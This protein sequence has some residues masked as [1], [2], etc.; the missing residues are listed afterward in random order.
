METKQKGFSLI[1]LVISLSIL[2]V[3]GSS[4]AYGLVGGVRAYIS[5]AEVV[6]TLD[7]LRYASERINRELREIRRSQAN[8]SDFD[9]S[10]M[11]LTTL[12]FIKSDGNEV[13]INTVLPLVTLAYQTPPGVWTLSDEVSSMRFSYF[14]N[15]GTTPATNSSDVAIIESELVLANNGNTYPI[16]SRIALRNSQ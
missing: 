10:S 15:D 14:Q 13:T 4:A 8:A 1:E 11:T 3:L 9:I 6:Q 5:N 16:R 7:K 2:A 12:S